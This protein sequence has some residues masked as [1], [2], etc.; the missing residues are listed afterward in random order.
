MPKAMR[1]RRSD[2]SKWKVVHVPVD[3]ETFDALERLSYADGRSRAATAWLL[4]K[5]G[6]SSSLGLTFRLSERRAVQSKAEIF[7]ELENFRARAEKALDY[8]A[9]AISAGT[10]RCEQIRLGEEIRSATHPPAGSTERVV[11]GAFGPK[12]EAR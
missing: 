5:A 11:R 7:A 6:V 1:R 4:I 2:G 3:D 10:T 12:D 9:R 8:A